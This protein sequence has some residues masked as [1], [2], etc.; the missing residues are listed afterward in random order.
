VAAKVG[1]ERQLALSDAAYRPI[2]DYAPS[3]RLFKRPVLSWHARMGHLVVRMLR[4]L[5]LFYG[6]R[7]LQGFAPTERPEQNGR[8][9]GCIQTLAIPCAPRCCIQ[10][11]PRLCDGT[12]LLDHKSSLG[13][14]RPIKPSLGPALGTLRAW[15]CRVFEIN[16]GMKRSSIPEQNGGVARDVHRSC[17]KMCCRAAFATCSS[18]CLCSPRRRA[19]RTSEDRQACCA[20]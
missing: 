1:A 11:F 4:H 2:T 14:S 5:L 7:L 17:Y 6:M 12:C 8:D 9:A 3:K 19:S 13:S 20:V 15:G 10:H 16:T 18:A